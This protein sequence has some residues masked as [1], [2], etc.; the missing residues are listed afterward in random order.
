MFD[1]LERLYDRVD[2]YFLAFAFVQFRIIIIIAI[3]GN[4]KHILLLLIGFLKTMC[5]ENV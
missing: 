5:I 4:F 3:G 2:F 1:L